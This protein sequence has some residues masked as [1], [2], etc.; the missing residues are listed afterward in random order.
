[1]LFRSFKDVIFK[2][3]KIIVSNSNDVIEITKLETLCYIIYYTSC[4]I[5]KYKLWYAS[6]V[7][8]KNISI[9]QRQVIH[10]IIDLINSLMEVNS[11]D[12]KNYLYEMI[13]YKIITK[14]N[15]LFK[16][17]DILKNIEERENKK[18]TVNSAT[19][20]IQILKSSIKSI[21]LPDKFTIFIDELRKYNFNNTLFEISKKMGERDSE[22]ILKNEIEK[23]NK[24][25]EKDNLIQLARI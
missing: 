19:N 2:N 4:M 12:S 3:L 17:D 9:I 22:L 14:V 24:N 1:M 23:I 7:T 10:T 18:I 15:T 16:N 5:S 8:E 21:L 25:Y 6:D 11:S 13:A 20:K